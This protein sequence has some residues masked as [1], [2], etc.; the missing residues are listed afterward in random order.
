M[1]PH[2]AKS[3]I[4]VLGNHEDCLWTKSDKYAPVFAPTPSASS[5]A[6]LLNRDG[7]SN[8]A[9]A[10]TQSIKVFNHLTKSP[11]SNFPLKILMLRKTST[12]YS[13]THCTVSIAAL[14]IGMKRSK[15]SY[16]NLDFAKMHMTLVFSRVL[17]LT[18]MTR[19]THLHHHHWL[20]GYM[21][22][23]SFISQLTQMSNANSNSYW[24]SMSPS[25][26]WVPS[27]GSSVNTF[28][29]K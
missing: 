26:S 20:L 29:G 24:R 14:N 15:W 8:R 1:R 4:V 27:N 13:S 9:I 21:L 2:R 12:G 11:L 22:T 6:W 17:S 16:T 28:S 10:L 5:S 3:C 23:T 19:P 25:I 7:F 18:T